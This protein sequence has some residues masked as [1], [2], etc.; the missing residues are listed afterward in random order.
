M[1]HNIARWEQKLRELD[2]S[3]VKLAGAKYPEQLIG[4]IH[5]PG[6][7]TISENELVEA[8]VETLQGQFA[9]FNRGLDNLVI[10]AGGI[11]T[12][13]SSV[14]AM[15][16]QHN[17]LA[18]AM[19]ALIPLPSLPPGI[20]GVGGTIYLLSLRLFAIGGTI[21]SSDVQA[22][23]TQRNGW[24][25]FGALPTPR[26]GLAVAAGGSLGGIYAIGGRSN[27][28]LVLQ[29]VVEAIIP[30]EGL[31]STTPDGVPFVPM[32]TARERAAATTG[33]EG[34]IYV[35]GGSN[36][37]DTNTSAP[38][39][40]LEIYHPDK[41]AWVSAKPMGTAR[42]SCAAATGKDGRIY[43]IGGYDGGLP[44]LTSV[45]VYDPATGVWA[46][47]APMSTPRSQLAA[48]TG[49]DGRI[50][51]IGGQSRA[52]V[53]S[54]VEIY[55]PSID[56]WSPGPSMSTERYG[57]AA[58]IGPDGRLYAIGGND[59]MNVLN[60]VEALSF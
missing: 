7:T 22:F 51:A 60:S 57:L 35:I 45:E 55:D 9:V 32:P 5:R 15:P 38:L 46:S 25:A 42:D 49:P 43:A 8:A 12:G 20:G 21:L 50:Y 53:F 52:D 40:A 16:N 23:N 39:S 1:S 19:G 11:G 10:T 37:N 14:P 2:D 47:V 29:S 26:F 6:W 58:A 31:T 4:I 27:P 41:N 24:T 48:A 17:Y 3:L 30:L 59:G 54:S 56:S 18:A 33:K 28:G 36:S 13:W 44:S 34:L